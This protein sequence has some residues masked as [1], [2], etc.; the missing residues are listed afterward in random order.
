MNIKDNL[1][2]LVAFTAL[3]S[4]GLISLIE[5]AKAGNVIIGLLDVSMTIL[6]TIVATATFVAIIRNYD[7]RL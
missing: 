2:K 5:A 1:I 7:T 3:A 4:I 6:G